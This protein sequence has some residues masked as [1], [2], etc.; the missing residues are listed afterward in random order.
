MPEKGRKEK[1][2][3]CQ[4]GCTS[5][6]FFFKSVIVFFLFWFF[7]LM[8]MNFDVIFVAFSNVSTLHSQT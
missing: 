3:K 2:N 6:V 5:S 8:G 1:K 7:G 4:F